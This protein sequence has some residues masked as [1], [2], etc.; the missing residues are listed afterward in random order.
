[1]NRSVS[2]ILLL[3]FLL[4]PTV[5]LAQPFMGMRNRIP[6]D[7]NT[8]ILINAEKMFGSPLA[9]REHWEARRK[10]AYDAGISA[11][12]PDATQVILA[13]RSDHEFGESIWELGLM[14]LR[15]ER[16]V[17][18]VAARYGGSMDEIN[19]R[20]AVRLPGDH[21]VIQMGPSLLASYS[22]ANRQDVARWLRSTDVTPAG[23][24]LHPYLQ[25]AFGYATKVG[26]PIVMAID[27]DGSISKEEVKQRAASLDFLKNM[28]IPID[29]LADLIHGTRGITL[30]ISIDEN[31]VGAIRVDFDES[32]EILAQI[33]KPLL[34]N[35]LQRQGA[36]ID[37]IREW[38][39]SVEGNTFML[40][41]KLSD[42]GTRKVMSVL[43]LPAS[44]SQAMHDATSPGSD[45]EATAKL[46]ATQQYWKSLN[47]MMDDLRTKPKR[48]HVKTFG[49]AAMWYDRYARK[50][51][52]LPIMNVD[53]DLLN[54]GATIS[55]SFRNCEAI[56]KGVGMRTSLRTASNNASSGG[57]SNGNFGG[58][59]ANSGTMG[60]YGI[61]FGPTGMTSSISPMNA[62]LQEK[63]RTD[64]IIRGQERTSG[65]AN[66]QQ[67][68][69]QIDEATAAMRRELVSKYSA[70]F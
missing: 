30:G 53:E 52:H 70:D 45:Q 48:D 4:T 14:K 19:G 27:I 42:E 31:E 62:S 55:S 46:L 41:G 8:L 36:M 1:M 29:Q 33:G 20:S 37:D 22:P 18:S 15:S 10:A 67:I 3:A 2:Y 17:S 38:Q 43:A 63:G 7:A 61:N 25:Q 64:A 69:Q 58:Y 59:R 66:V 23:G 35:V 50:I 47:S 60:T 21:Y 39:P 26:T 16:N 28:N 13:G 11:L 24:G 65:A 9:N 40:R 44:M 6:A 12:P 34:I 51:D 56:M 54:F 68:W 49:Q 32:P 57:Y 5:A